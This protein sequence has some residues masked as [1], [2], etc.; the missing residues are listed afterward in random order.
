MNFVIIGERAEKLTNDF[1]GSIVGQ[2]DCYKNRGF[3]N[4]IAHNY[5]GIDAEKISQIITDN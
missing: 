4:I 2:I 1:K 5:F 3:R